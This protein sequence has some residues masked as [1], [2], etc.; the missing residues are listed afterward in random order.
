MLLLIIILMLLAGAWIGSK[1]GLL[2]GIINI[3]SCILGILVLII[4][5]KGIGNFMEGSFLS[6]LMA[7][8]LLMSIKVIHKIIELIIDS[9]KLVRALP[10]GKLVDKIAGAALGFTEALFLIWFLFLLFGSFDMF[11]MNNWIMEQ[12]E[13]S[14]ILKFIYYSNYLVK[15]L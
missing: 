10:A 15:F 2:E 7:L 14:R 6:V 9:F 12:V 11:N 5:V 4:V 3:I 1:K 13:S 8:I